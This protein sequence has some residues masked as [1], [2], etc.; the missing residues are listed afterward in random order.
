[1]AR[2]APSGKTGRPGGEGGRAPRPPRRSRRDDH[3]RA[4]ARRADHYDDPAF[5]Y[6]ENWRGR[7]DEHAA[8][9]AA[10]DRL[11]AGRRFA[12][13]LDVGGGYGRLSRHL[14][15]SAGEIILA[16]PGAQLGLARAYLRSAPAVRCL[17]AQ[18]SDLRLP[19][20][21][22]DVAMLVLQPAAVRRP[23]PARPA[24]P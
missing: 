8:E 23:R 22:V 20:G 9:Q 24:H 16:E 12:R 10:I 3:A 17:P 4:P 7:D 6:Q 14:V 19:D 18:A 1:M 5:D 13:A 15:N 11:L 2:A 21:S